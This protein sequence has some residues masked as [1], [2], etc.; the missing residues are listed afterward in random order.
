RFGA[1]LIDACLIGFPFGVASHVILAWAAGDRAL[2]GW[3]TAAGQA[4]WLATLSLYF[5]ALDGLLG[6]T[7]GKKLAGLRVQGPQPGEAPGL[8]R[9]L[10]RTGIFAAVVAVPVSVLVVLHHLLGGALLTLRE[11]PL[12][13]PR[14]PAG[15]STTRAASGY[16]GPH[17]WLSDTRVVR[18]PRPVRAEPLTL[19]GA[20]TVVGGGPRPAELPEQLG[21]FRLGAPLVWTAE[22]KVVAAEDIAL[23]RPVWVELRHAEA[24]PLDAGRRDVVR[25][26]RLRWLAG[27]VAGGWRWDAFQAP[28]G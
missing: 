2:T 18:A 13:P 8:R 26:T 27:G 19:P 5:T 20:A 21:A 15:L 23:A 9:A 14:G 22:R 16:R 7:P 24:A 17:E 6:W 3:L 1:Y 11:L 4:L 12:P 28:A 25:P 10:V